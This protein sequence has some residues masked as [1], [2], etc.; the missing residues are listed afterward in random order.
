M[1]LGRG[2]A[3]FRV[4]RLGGDKVRKARGNSADALDAA[5]VFLCRDF[6]IE[7]LRRRFKA[8]MDVL[9]A[10]SRY[11]LSLFLGRLNFLLNETRFLFWGRCIL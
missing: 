2:S 11:G 10:M 3:S 6:S 5:N 7:P 9:G 4:V 8:V 1:V